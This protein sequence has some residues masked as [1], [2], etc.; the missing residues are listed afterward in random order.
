MDTMTVK[1]GDETIV[2]EDVAV[3]EVWI[4]GGQSNMEFP[5]RF[6]KHS[7]E[8]L[9]QVNPLLRFYDVP[10]KFYEEQDQD[11]DYSNVGI[12]R[13]AEGKRIAITFRYTGAELKLAGECVEA[14]SVSIEGIEAA[15]TAK[16]QGD[17]LI[18]TL[19]EDEGKPVKVDFAQGAWYLVNLFNEAG[20]PAIPFTLEC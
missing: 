9:N 14:L 13:K 18:I 10:E 17:E 1:S 8:E 11:F 3:G 7:A 4:A 19:E 20:I 12:W 6:E 15:H 16:V 5:L 2:I